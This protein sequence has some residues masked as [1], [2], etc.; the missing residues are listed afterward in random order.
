MMQIY[1]LLPDIDPN[2][3]VPLHVYVPVILESDGEEF[4]TRHF[5]GIPWQ[6]QEAAGEVVV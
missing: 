6:D 3:G 2:E 1:L 5:N 4:A